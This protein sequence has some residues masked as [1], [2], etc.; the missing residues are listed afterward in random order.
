MRRRL[1]S[2]V[3]AAVLGGSLVLP[4]AAAV[5]AAAAPLAG[6]SV[7][8]LA[9]FGGR[10][11][12]GTDSGLQVQSGRQWVPVGGPVAGREVN[13]LAAGGGWLLA[14]TDAGVLRSQ[15]G[16]A[17][18]AAGLNG[19]RVASLGAAGGALLAGSGTDSTKTGIV[20]RS[21]DLGGSW[22]PAAGTAPLLLGL[23]GDMV[24][25]VLAPQGGLGAWA[26]TGGGGAFHSADG[27]GSWSAASAGMASSWVTSFWSQPGTGRLLAGTDD[28]LYSWSGSAW[29][30]VAF[31]QQDPWVQ[32]L[33]TGPDGRPLAGT[34]D[35]AVFAQDAAGHWTSMASGLPSVLSLLA[36]SGGGVLV[37]TSDGLACI[38][39]PSGVAPAPGQPSGARPAA[40]LPPPAA[41]AG[42]TAAGRPTAGASGLGAAASSPDAALGAGAA[43]AGT[44]GSAAA[45]VPARW[46]IAGG[47]VALSALLF[48]AGQ[49]RARRRRGSS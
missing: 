19:E 46:W 22:S 9:S 24:Q 13:A 30:A 2:L 44:G 36:L 48:A 8:S 1:A 37:G 49:V 4:L 31:P 28:G 26:G 47:L 33:A 11:Y 38:A 39:C 32:A 12:A 45:G 15:D 3:P 35:G 40:S 18:S 14:A 43:P 25:A 7:L 21:D 17:W 42:A 20:Q 10:L 16:V 27:R 41:R 29:S 34:Y 6:S 23:S 5:P